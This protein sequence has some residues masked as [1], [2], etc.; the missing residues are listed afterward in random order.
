MKQLHLRV[1]GMA[2]PRCVRDVTARL[3]DVPGVETIAADTATN[4]VLLRGTMTA[5]DV[6][7]AFAGSQHS[8][9]LVA[10]AVVDLSP[11]RTEV[12]HP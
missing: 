4:T 9:T 8:A 2:C 6:L 3:R 12:A 10:D 1:T 7:D 5:Q 11:G